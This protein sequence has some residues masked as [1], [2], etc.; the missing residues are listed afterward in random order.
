MLN[1]SIEVA[2]R[3]GRALENYPA[4]EF[5]IDED[6]STNFRTLKSRV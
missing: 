5:V 6:E 4:H 2:E 1:Y 3:I